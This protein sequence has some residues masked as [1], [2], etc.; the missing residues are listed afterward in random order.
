MEETGD[1][2]SISTNILED[3]NQ[4]DLIKRTQKKDEKFSLEEVKKDLQLFKIYSES[5]LTERDLK[6]NLTNCLG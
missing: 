2:P 3:L 6:R 4:H 1:S 5:S